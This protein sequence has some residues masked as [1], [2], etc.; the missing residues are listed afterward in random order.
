MIFH[1]PIVL[2][3]LWLLGLTLPY[4]APVLN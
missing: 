3:M 1:V 4:V 2:A